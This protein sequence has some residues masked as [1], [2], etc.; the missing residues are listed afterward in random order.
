MRILALDTTTRSGSAAIVEDD[1]IVAERRGDAARS[2]A[3]RLPH[4][5]LDLL[6]AHNWTTASIDL[7]AVAAGPGSFTGLRVGI[8]TIQ[9]LAFVHHR[10]VAAVSALEALGQV[11]GAGLATGS[12]VGVW[13]DA[14][15]R[16]VFSALYRVAP[17]PAFDPRR[18]VEVAAP[19]VAAPD[20]TL[21]RWADADR[22]APA[23]VAGDGAVALAPLLASRYPGAIIAPH[24]CLAGAIGRIGFVHAAAGLTLDPA[25]VRPLYIRRP[26]AEVERERRQQAAG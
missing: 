7:F 9:G 20:A 5:L 25:G 3:E 15:R 12:L 4:D 18:L 22:G 14:Q 1:A 11:A 21:E 2:M 23:V 19:A 6:G 8:A 10:P 13:M 24:P 26:D 17:F 16:D